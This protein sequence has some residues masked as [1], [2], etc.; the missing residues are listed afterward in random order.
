MLGTSLKCLRGRKKASMAKAYCKPRAGRSNHKGSHRTWQ[1]FGFLPSVGL[2]H[3]LNY[4][5]L[6]FRSPFGCCVEDG[7][8]GRKW[9]QRWQVSAWLSFLSH[10]TFLCSAVTFFIR[11]SMPSCPAAC[12]LNP[13][14]LAPSIV[15]ISLI[16]LIV[17]HLP[18]YQPP[19][20]RV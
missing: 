2:M 1:K 8:L 3:D 19:T 20:T 11:T 14:F 9:R 17:Y 13:L 4:S 6:Y 7:L 18:L 15:Y 16:M 12:T 5:W 10:F